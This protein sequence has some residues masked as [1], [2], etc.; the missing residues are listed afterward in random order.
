MLCHVFFGFTWILK[1]CD[2][3]HLQVCYSEITLLNAYETEDMAASLHLS[4]SV[5]R[6]VPVYLFTLFRFK[7]LYYFHFLKPSTSLHSRHNFVLFPLLNRLDS[8]LLGPFQITHYKLINKYKALL[9][10]KLVHYNLSGLSVLTFPDLSN[11]LIY[12]ILHHC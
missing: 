11:G 1:T 4:H 10:I 6:S 7:A 5:T 8:Q 3:C 9:K 12:I 2:Y